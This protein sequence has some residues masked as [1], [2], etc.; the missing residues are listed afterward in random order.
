MDRPSE[1]VL[2]LE[3]GPNS[4]R[5]CS[6]DLG[7]AEL[8]S[9]GQPLRSSRHAS[10]M[11]ELDPIEVW[12]AA[13]EVIHGLA[14]AVPDL[15][16]RAVAL[17]LTGATG[18]LCL[19]DEDGEPVRPLVAALAAGELEPGAAPSAARDPARLLDRL[20]RSGASELDRAA[21]ALDLRGWLLACLTGRPLRAPDWAASGQTVDGT[22]LEER[23]RLTPPAATSALPL[24]LH[25]A[26]AAASG[27]WGETPVVIAPP[28]PVAAG[29]AAGLAD[30]AFE[31]GVALLETETWLIRRAGRSGPGQA[32]PWPDLPALRLSEGEV[33]GAALDWLVG[34]AQGLLADAGL[35][36]LGIAD[37]HSLVERQAAGTA[38][39][40][41]CFRR[42][43]TG[44]PGLW[45]LE[46]LSAGSGFADV[47]RAIY[48]ATARSCRN[49]F[50]R[51][52]GLPAE[53][54]ITG[55]LAATTIAQ[56]ILAVQLDVPI[57]LLQ[58][59]V[60][61]AAGAA[62][63]ALRAVGAIET[64]PGATASWVERFLDPPL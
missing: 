13:V 35:I 11:V 12:Q 49:G 47:A 62:L 58:R 31:G 42:S 22:A 40:T 8:G 32:T 43:A 3:V 37:L 14:R 57:R 24:A 50:E 27:L 16:R 33:G 44:P 64:L 26:A 30:P 10:A 56:A 29:L 36:G 41:L 23:D 45:T 1:V 51:D 6:F 34:F 2:G 25:P 61:A 39:G 38:P 5:G 28:A 18:G 60:P 59:P 19:V 54:R 15:G 9:A 21:H 46:G 20:V 55:T 48:E 4:V 17:G 7:G 63:C 53:V 52:G